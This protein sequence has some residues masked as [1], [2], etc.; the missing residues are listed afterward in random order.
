MPEGDT[1]WRTAAALRPR[2]E[3]RTIAAARPAP[4]GRL[5]G[6]R[7]TGVEAAGKHL[8]IRVEGG[9]VLHSHMRMRGAWYIFA[10]GQPW[11]RP[12]SRARAVLEL[13]GVVAVCFDAPVVE[14]VRDDGA[15][16]AHLGP[17]LLGARVD[18]DE[19]VARAR[20]SRYPSIG[21][22]LLDQRVAAGVGNI[23]RCD[24]LWALGIDPWAPVSRL[25]DATVARVYATARDR[26]RRS[27]AGRGFGR[28][29][30]VHGRAGRPCPRCAT[31]VVCRA[32]GERARL[33]FSC[34]RCQAALAPAGSAA[35]AAPPR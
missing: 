14:V 20:R 1:I 17:D 19:V 28:N 22:V 24:S 34:P 4:I 7:V 26:M 13:D 16:T 3:G 6:R 2:L 30:G 9:L 27:A 15:A 25:D 33:T 10:P 18:L 11:S 31:P 21:E 29:A 8:L 35:V 23:H 12:A 5:A 32:Q